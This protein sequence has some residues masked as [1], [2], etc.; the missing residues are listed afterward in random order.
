M[1]WH[2]PRKRPLE[3]VL[4]L[5]VDALILHIICITAVLRSP[6]MKPNPK[7]N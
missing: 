2:Y 7:R 3:N 1:K 5:V 4:G 6:L